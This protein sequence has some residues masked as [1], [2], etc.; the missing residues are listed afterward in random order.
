[1]AL[2]TLEIARML[3]PTESEEGLKA[4]FGTVTAVNTPFPPLKPKYSGKICPS[5]AAMPAM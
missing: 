2:D 4:R 3:S 5:M 1:M